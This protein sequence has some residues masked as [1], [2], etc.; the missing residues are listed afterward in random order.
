[1]AEILLAFIGAGYFALIGL[2]VWLA[3]DA[4]RQQ[5]TWSAERTRLIRTAL[6]AG[7]PGAEVFYGDTRP[8]PE[9]RQRDEDAPPPGTQPI[10][11]DGR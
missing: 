4:H 9:P 5:D 11:L 3:V 2:V 1:M 7:R 10:G 8:T 6:A